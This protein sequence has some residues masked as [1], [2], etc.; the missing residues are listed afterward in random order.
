MAQCVAITKAG[1]EC[2]NGAISESDLCK[3]HY[4]ISLQ[5][6]A[7]AQWEET[8][9]TNRKTPEV[10]GVNVPEK[11]YY[12]LSQTENAAIIVNTLANLVKFVDGFLG[13][14]H[15]QIHLTLTISTKSSPT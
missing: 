11:F 9:S 14:S 3:E 4:R 5:E 10:P 15:D 7:N 6:A 1:Y 13:N 12:S 8:T 2:R